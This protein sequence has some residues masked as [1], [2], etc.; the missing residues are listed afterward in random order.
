MTLFIPHVFH[1]IAQ[2]TYEKMVW[3]ATFGIVALVKNS[4][5][6][7]KSTN[8]KNERKPM[9]KNGLSLK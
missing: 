8:E 4:F 2:S 5:S 3:I 9:T 7:F 6:R 1:V